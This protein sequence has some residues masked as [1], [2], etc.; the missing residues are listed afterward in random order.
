[1]N[2]QAIKERVQQLKEI[3][4]RLRTFKDSAHD[5]DLGVTILSPQRFEK[6]IALYRNTDDEQL[7]QGLLY[8][9]GKYIWYN[10]YHY[11]HIP[12]GSR[13]DLENERIYKDLEKA[14]KPLF[15]LIE[16]Q[17][18]WEIEKLNRPDGFLPSGS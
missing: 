5:K 7:K 15:D 14:D 13:E 8:S 16:K 12:K 2:R 17:V 3:N 9:I 11:M 1:M 4:E 18:D 6:A 10:Y